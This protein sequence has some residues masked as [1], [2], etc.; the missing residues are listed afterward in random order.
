MPLGYRLKGIQIKG[1]HG[2]G[3][4]FFLIRNFKRPCFR[5]RQNGLSHH[6]SKLTYSQTI[7][8]G[9]LLVTRRRGCGFWVSTFIVSRCLQLWDLLKDFRESWWSAVRGRGEQSVERKHRAAQAGKRALAVT[10]K[11]ASLQSAPRNRLE[12]LHYCQIILEE[13]L[14]K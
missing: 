10:G 13:T 14:M 11:T 4:F 3:V 2:L 6:I 5:I 12:A 1:R 9:F 8:R 7:W